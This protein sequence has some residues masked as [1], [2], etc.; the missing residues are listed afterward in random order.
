MERLR[1]SLKSRLAQAAKD[2]DSGL[3]AVHRFELQILPKAEES[4]NLSERAFAAG[5]FDFLQVLVARCI[6]F[7]SNLG[8]VEARKQL[9]QVS[10]QV[11]GLLL[12]GGLAETVDLT[13][14]DRLRGQA[15]SGR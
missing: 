1:I 3:A 2:H 8:A 15:L 4:L 10:A 7:D 9:A 14:D 13:D 11:D 12:S 6:D 5:E